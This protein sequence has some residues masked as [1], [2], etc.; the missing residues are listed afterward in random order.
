MA[1]VFFPKRQ[2]CKK[3][4]KGLGADGAPVYLG[5]YDTPRCAGVAVPVS[6]LTKAPRECVTQRDGQWVWKRRYRS[7]QEIPDRI[8]DDVGTSVYRCQHCFHLHLGRTLVATKS[9]TR[10]AV[11]AA[12]TNVE[13]RGLRDR[14]SLADLLI[15]ARSQAT[16]KQ[17]AEAIK[18]RPIRIKEWEDAAFDA[19]S[20]DVLFKLLK[21]YRIDLV[22]V[23]R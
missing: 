13:N 11:G 3:C 22:A 15:K 19:P 16:H 7:E 20:L 18:V 23:F 21:I 1:E 4:G 17:V 2:R 14:A 6:D 10:G 12:A 5:L 9:A 8:R